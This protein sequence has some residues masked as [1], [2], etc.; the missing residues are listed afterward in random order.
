MNKVY[1]IFVVIA[2][3][4]FLIILPLVLSIKKS[5]KSQ[6][7]RIEYF[8]TLLDTLRNKIPIIKKTYKYNYAV[9]KICN[10]KIAKGESIVIIPISS[11][12]TNYKDFL[13]YHE[14]C[15]LLALEQKFKGKIKLTE[16][17]KILATI[18]NL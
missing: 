13:T 7:K 12:Y 9:C 11:F 6:E 18:C 14:G 16:K 2:V 15:F 3:I 4:L 10:G 1:L 8:E 17:G 5:R